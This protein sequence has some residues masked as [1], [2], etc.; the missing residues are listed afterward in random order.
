MLA[1]SGLLALV[2]LADD[3]LS[4]H[5]LFDDA[6][7]SVAGLGESTLLR[8]GSELLAF[9]LLGLGIAAYLVA[10]RSLLAR[11]EIGLLIV[12]GMLFACSLGIDMLPR[13]WLAAVPVPTWLWDPVEDG[14]KLAGIVLFASY[15][16]RTTAM[17]LSRRPVT[18]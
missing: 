5:E 18:G 11:T 4:L 2:L 15:Y 7:M 8:N 12:A 13:S 17:V 3:Y 16:V 14:L 10:F 9:G 1:G 6:A